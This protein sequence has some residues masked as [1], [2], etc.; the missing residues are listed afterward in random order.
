[1]TGINSYLGVSGQGVSG[2]LVDAAFQPDF[3]GQLQAQLIGTIS[4]VLWGVVMG[5]LVHVP[6]ALIAQGLQ[7][8]EGR[9]SSRVAAADFVAEAAP[10]SPPPPHRRQLNPVI[11]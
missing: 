4:L 1:M 11:Q 9:R 10:S 2:L 8:S 6:L 7:R 3:P 5:F